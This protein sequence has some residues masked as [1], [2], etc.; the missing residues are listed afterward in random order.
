M[1]HIILIPVCILSAVVL[2]GCSKEENLSEQVKT[3]TTTFQAVIESGATKTV[4]GNGDS[5][6]E[7]HPVLWTSGDAIGI[8]SASASG[9]GRYEYRGTEDTEFAEFSGDP[10]Q[11]ELFYAVYPY[12]GDAVM[13]GSVLTL[14]LPSVQEYAEASFAPSSSPMV[15]KSGSTDLEFKNLCG[16]LKLN[17]TGTATV[18]SVVFRSS[19]RG[20]SGQAT[21]DMNYESVPE[22]VMSGDA[23]TSVTLDCGEGVALS[24]TVPVPFYIVLPAGTYDEFSIEVITADGKVMTKSN[25]GLV[26]NRSMVRPTSDVEFVPDEV[27]GDR[28][29]LIAFYNATDGPNWTDNTNWC[30]DEPLD[31]WYGVTTDSEGRVTEIALSDNGLSGDAGNTLAPLSKLTYLS[32][33]SN[34]LI[35]LDLSANTALTLLDC[36][37]NNL[38]D[39]DLSNNIALT[40]L[41]CGSNSLNDLDLSANTALTLLWCYINN[42]SELDLSANTA[43]TYLSCYNNNLSELDLSGN[44]ALTSLSCYNNNLSELDLSGNVALTYLYCS[45]NNLSELDLSNNTALTYLRCYGNN[46]SE[47]DLSGNVALTYLYCSSNNLSELDLSANTALTL[48]YCSDN[49]LSDLDL[50]GNVALTDLR[51]SNNSLSG[52]DLS[53]NTALTTLWCDNNNLS[54][55]DLSNNTALT[56]LYCYGNNMTV[57]DIR[58]NVNLGEYVWVGCQTDADGN[59]EYMYL[60]VTEAQLEQ[61]NNTW[62][63]NGWNEY[64]VVSTRENYFDISPQSFEVPASGGEITVN[65]STDQDYTLDIVNPE[66]IT[67]VS[68]EGVKIGELVFKVAENPDAAERTGMIQFCAGANCYNVTVTQAGGDGNDPSGDNEGFGNDD[69]YDL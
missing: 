57:L 16:L 43:L 40:S 63:G 33:Y 50:S 31:T 23:G 49:N 38:S 47:L 8:T 46:L 5:D 51:C 39:L 35:G 18:R 30:S 1:K 17:L 12:S 65:I 9:F 25:S 28:E 66:W 24:G 69:E 4:L 54:A 6:T 34:S 14:E 42:L 41:Y 26:I 21:V 56:S 7:S 29:A 3:S 15:A 37:N 55:L 60:Y 2:A 67:M 11:G 48:L 22:L 52:L 27:L 53:N 19:G 36:S 32:C 64:V 62:S 45:S 68:G 59:Y 58:N 13:S 10:I 20:V 61:W 44:T